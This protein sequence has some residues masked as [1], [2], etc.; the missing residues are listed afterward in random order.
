MMDAEIE[1]KLIDI[2][3]YIVCEECPDYKKAIKAISAL[4]VGTIPAEKEVKSFDASD[5]SGWGQV[6]IQHIHNKVHYF[7]RCRTEM[8]SRWT[9]KEK[10]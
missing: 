10:L 7:N 1:K 5:S 9:S 8:L 6:Y 4:V 2:F 3:D